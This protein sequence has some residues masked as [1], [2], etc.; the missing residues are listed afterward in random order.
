[1]V[2][3]QI[4]SEGCRR[5]STGSSDCCTAPEQ[6]LLEGIGLGAVG[7]LD[8][9]ALEEPTSR[10]LGTLAPVRS[11]RSP[12]IALR[13]CTPALVCTQDCCRAARRKDQMVLEA[14]WKGIRPGRRQKKHRRRGREECSPWRGCSSLRGRKDTWIGRRRIVVVGRSVSIGVVRR[15]EAD[16]HGSRRWSALATRHRDTRVAFIVDEGAIVYFTTA[17]R[18]KLDNVYL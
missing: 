15:R 7:H 11:R 18:T 8:S 12:V 13:E 2:G 4:I 14:C 1:M 17:L 9:P 16:W 6:D 5:C 10:P 3:L